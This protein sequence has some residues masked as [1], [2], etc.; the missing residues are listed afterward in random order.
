[1]I[2]IVADAVLCAYFLSPFQDQQYQISVIIIILTSPWTY[3]KTDAVKRWSEQIYTH[4]RKRVG[5]SVGLP[6]GRSVGHSPIFFKQ[7]K[8]QKWIK[9][10]KKWGRT[11]HL[12]V[13]QPCLN[14]RKFV[15]PPEYIVNIL[16]DLFFEHEECKKWITSNRGYNDASSCVFCNFCNSFLFIFETKWVTNRW[17]NRLMDELTDGPMDRPA[18]PVEIRGCI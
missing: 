7:G 15:Q 5:P 13:Y 2:N 11:H 9:S 8:Q 14:E 16:K 18:Y 1:M 4:L 3:W 10:V 6:T 12:A 17:T